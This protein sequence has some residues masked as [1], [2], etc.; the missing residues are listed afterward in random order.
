M[1]FQPISGE[2]DCVGEMRTPGVGVVGDVVLDGGD[3]RGI[4]VL[5]LV[6]LRRLVGDQNIQPF[7]SHNFNPINLYLTNNDIHHTNIHH[8]ENN[9]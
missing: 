8:R 3:P 9:W 7:S 6:L 1:N 4:P 5:G 2:I